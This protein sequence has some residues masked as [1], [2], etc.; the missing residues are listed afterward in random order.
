MELGAATEVRVEV[1]LVEV[2][3]VEVAL[4]EVVLIEMALEE[5]LDGLL[6]GSPLQSPNLD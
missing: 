2:A 6:G 4:V 3:L 5:E 1:A